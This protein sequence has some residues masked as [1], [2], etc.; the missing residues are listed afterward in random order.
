[1][2]KV[3]E[4]RLLAEIGANHL[5]STRLAKEMIDV[6]VE[7]GMKYFKF[8]I[9]NM[10]EIGE[11]PEWV[12]YDY[13]SH[14]SLKKDQVYELRDYCDNKGAFFFASIFGDWSL[15]V[16][17]EIEMPLYKIAS[18]SVYTKDG[19]IS[20][21]AEKIYATGKP[22]VSSLG[23]RKTGWAIPDK[24]NNV[25]L[26]CV[27]NYPTV[28]EDITWPEF[29]GDIAGFSDH[30]IGTKIT[31]EAIDLGAVVIE[32][33]YTLDKTLY[34]PDQ[35]GSATPSEMKD[36]LDHAHQKYGK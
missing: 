30:T 8:Q 21:L 25:N 31:K 14:C 16:A 33:H 2:E 34:G 9:Y 20:P 1:M 27:S 4:F 18:R 29:G 26:Y 10:E 35:A 5:G 12:W 22:V 6:G 36:I 11:S 28:R 7:Q 3:M 24:E 19:E 13:I 15:E 23:Y 17:K 32:K